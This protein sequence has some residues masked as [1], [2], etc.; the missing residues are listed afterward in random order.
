MPVLADSPTPA[1]ACR[2]RRNRSPPRRWR[3]RCGCR[4][5]SRSRPA[6][7]AAKAGSRCPH[8]PGNWRSS[9]E[10]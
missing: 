8:R 2:K 3:S 6:P 10:R 1:G 9:R 4:S 5:W 7:L